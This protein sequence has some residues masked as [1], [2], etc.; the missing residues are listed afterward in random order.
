MVATTES[1]YAFVEPLAVPQLAV[2]TQLHDNLLGGCVTVHIFLRQDRI[3]PL[4]H[5]APGRDACGD[6]GVQGVEIDVPRAMQRLHQYAA[7]DVNPDDVGDYPLPEVASE[8][9]DTA[10]TGVHVGHDPDLAAAECV[11]GHQ[12]LYLLHRA[13]LYV[14][15]EDLDVVSLDSSHNIVA[16]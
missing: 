12:L 7:P 4:P 15:G 5:V 16:D 13:L 8:A 9:Y 6:V 14:V 2:A 3:R 10:R 11:D 1:A